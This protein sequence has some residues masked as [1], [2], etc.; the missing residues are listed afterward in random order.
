MSDV[1]SSTAAET[2]CCCFPPFLS[3]P[4]SVIAKVHLSLWVQET[5]GGRNCEWG[6]WV[7]C[8][9]PAERRLKSR[10]VYLPLFSFHAVILPALDSNLHFASHM[11]TY[12]IIK[13]Y[14]FK[15]SNKC[16]AF[17]L[18]A[19]KLT[20]LSLNHCSSEPTTLGNYSW[21]ICR[22]SLFHSI[23]QWIVSLSNIW[24]ST[25]K[26][27][28]QYFVSVLWREIESLESSFFL[29]STPLHSPHTLPFFS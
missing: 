19:W 5:K 29:P 27:Q 18:L 21:F 22:N 12:F 9:M 11:L 14:K 16:S 24:G 2:F 15:H 10:E 13:L 7:R 4:S 23:K 1:C 28:S 3:L 26:H 25:L 17:Q 8:V 6:L 20:H